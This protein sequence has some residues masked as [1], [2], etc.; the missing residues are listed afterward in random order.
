MRR[1]T[2]CFLARAEFFLASIEWNRVLLVNSGVNGTKIVLHYL[3][4]ALEIFTDKLYQFLGPCLIRSF[5]SFE[6]IAKKRLAV[7]TREL[8]SEEWRSYMSVDSCLLNLISHVELRKLF[9][10]LLGVYKRVLELESDTSVTRLFLVF[11]S[12]VNDLGSS[13][14]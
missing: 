4:V 13:V 3:M 10:T 1:W 7:A 6:S 14:V 5:L 11:E 12:V 2:D 8:L 9:P